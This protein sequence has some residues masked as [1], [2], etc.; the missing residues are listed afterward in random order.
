MKNTE[1]NADQPCFR[2]IRALNRVTICNTVKHIRD[3]KKT[4]SAIALSIC[5][6]VA[7]ATPG[8][9]KLR[10]EA[11]EAFTQVHKEFASAGIESIKINQRACW[12]VSPSRT[13]LFREYTAMGLDSIDAKL[14]Q[15]QPDAFFSQEAIRARAAEWL[16]TA[17]PPEVD[18]DMYHRACMSV[19]APLV[20]FEVLPEYA[21]KFS[22]QSQ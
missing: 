13:C 18:R 12:Q 10:A 21:P 14:Y 19:I 9:D 16:K 1:R 2:S 6:S 22:S 20:L 3:M 15:R 7:F 8:A 11:T 17:V 5:A 4:A